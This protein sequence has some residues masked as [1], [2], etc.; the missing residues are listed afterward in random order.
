MNKSLQKNPGRG[1]SPYGNQ[2]MIE[3]INEIREPNFFD[4][5]LI[6][7]RYKWSILIFIVIGMLVA[8]MIINS[9]TP[10]YRSKA[11]LLVE[12][13]AQNKQASLGAYEYV[14]SPRL[15]YQTQ[16]EIITSRNVAK[17]VIKNLDLLNDKRFMAYYYD[18]GKSSVTNDS[19]S[20]ASITSTQLSEA[21]ELED[22]VDMLLSALMIS[23]G[24]DSQVFNIEYEAPDPMLASD[25]T[26]AI[27]DAYINFGV[28]SRGKGAVLAT[29]WLTQQDDDLRLKL[30][31]S[32]TKLQGFKNQHS[33]LGSGSNQEVSNTRLSELAK[34][35]ITAQ[36]VRSDAEVRYHQISAIRKQNGDLRS[37]SSILNNVVIVK[38]K[39]AEIEQAREV[40]E[41]SQ[42]YG[43]NHPKLITAKTKLLK[44]QYAIN[45]VVDEIVENLRKEVSLTNAREQKLRGLI[46]L[47][48]ESARDFQSKDFQLGKLEQK[49]AYNR[50]MYENF[51]AK[52]TDIESKTNFNISNI[53]ILDPAH[54][55]L[56]PFSPNIKRIFILCTLIGAFI[57]ILFAFLRG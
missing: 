37:I 20:D 56:K 45:D 53:T 2:A 49:V 44:A 25:I 33:M 31:K 29:D 30:E 42:R 36:A 4:Y 13:I 57:G 51:L 34:Q 46:A 27:A 3:S 54:P 24:K 41:L 32:E 1:V 22:F 23:G 16:Y 55:V 8:V 28:S 18:Q 43:S 14:N 48:E 17:K 5:W 40:S 35:L 50:G 38:L 7:A 47:E 21:G 11:R 6:L 39:Q 52:A 10:K 15:F 19:L 9:V 26:N 12:P